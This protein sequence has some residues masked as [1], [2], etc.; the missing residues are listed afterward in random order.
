MK[1]IPGFL[2]A[3]RLAAFANLTIT[4]E[5]WRSLWRP[6]GYTQQLTPLWTLPAFRRLKR[7]AFVMRQL[8]ARMAGLH[9]DERT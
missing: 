7:N 2:A 6:G 3:A 1:N 5:N 4:A 9:T 8:R